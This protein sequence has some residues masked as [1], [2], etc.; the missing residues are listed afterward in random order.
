M[1][2]S[3]VARYAVLRVKDGGHVGGSTDSTNDVMSRK[4]QQRRG[5]KVSDRDWD[6]SDAY[7][8]M[9]DPTA[10]VWRQSLRGDARTGI[11]DQVAFRIDWS[12]FLRTQS[13]RTRTALAMLAAGHSQTKVANRPGATP[14]AVCQRLKRAE[15]EGLGLQQCDTAAHAY[16]MTLSKTS[17][18]PCNR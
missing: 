5:F 6:N 1:T 3:T 18:V 16:R 17:R 9:T 4:A 14:P 11:P 13:S 15:R 2:A 12:T 10:P 7:N 8:C